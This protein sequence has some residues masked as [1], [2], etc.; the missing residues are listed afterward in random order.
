MGTKKTPTTVK[1]IVY[2]RY[3]PPI[4]LQLQDV[5]KP[6]PKNNEVLIRVM[7]VEA[8]KSDCEMRSFNFVVKWFWLPLRL[9]IGLFKPK[10]PVLGGYFAGQVVEVGEDVVKLKIGE[11]IFGATKLRFGAYAEY[12]SLPD[13]YLLTPK[14]EN[15]SYVEAASVPL[16]G[17]NALHFMRKA[18]IRGGEHILINGAGGSIGVYAVQIAK[19]MGAEVT[20]VDSSIKKDM[21]I[22]IGADHFIDYTKEDFTRSENS[23]DVI[24]NMVAGSSYGYCIKLL[25]PKGRYIM[26]NPRLIDMIRSLITP[27]LTGKEVI[28]A[29]AGEKEEELLSLKKM[30]EQG[31]IKPVIDKIY[32]LEETAIAHHRIEK[33]ERSGPVVIEVAGN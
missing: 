31:K 9:A 33:E 8:T 10:R 13:H 7:A 3:G 12:L 22:R 2:T 16:G 15:V 32:P 19:S 4:V 28:F 23:Y 17:L 20:A 26:G 1:A 11:E 18:N 14:P 6:V 29:F 27:M 21:L 30:I 24:F 5:A 25:K